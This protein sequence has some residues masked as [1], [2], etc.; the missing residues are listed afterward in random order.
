MVGRTV[1]AAPDR[2]T[3][4]ILGQRAERDPFTELP[5]ASQAAAAGQ[6]NDCPMPIPS[7]LLDVWLL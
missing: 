4:Q 2:R 5:S 7:I 1:L 3:W 6:E